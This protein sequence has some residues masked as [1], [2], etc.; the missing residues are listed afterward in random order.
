M[1]ESFSEASSIIDL[2]IWYRQ[3][4]L[5]VQVPSP[6]S[7]SCPHFVAFVGSVTRFAFGCVGATSSADDVAFFDASSPFFFG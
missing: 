3:C 4:H 1:L 5:P 2:T 7:G 6:G